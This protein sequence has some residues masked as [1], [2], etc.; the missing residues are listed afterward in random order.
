MTP[1]A[2]I[3]TMLLGQQSWSEEL[4]LDPPTGP[5][6]SIIHEDNEASQNAASRGASPDVS[7][8]LPD[9]PRTA[10]PAA[11]LS[12]S[13]RSTVI[14]RPGLGEEVRRASAAEE[15]ETDEAVRR[16]TLS[17]AVLTAAL[18]RR[19]QA[20]VSGV[21][22]SL[23]HVLK[24]AQGRTE[25][26][27][28]VLA[29][30]DLVLKVAQHHYAIDEVGELASIAKSLSADTLLLEAAVAT[31][32]ARRREAR[33]NAVQAQHELA[34]KAGW[35]YH[36]ESDGLPVPTETPILGRYDTKFDLIFARR[37]PPQLAC[38]IHGTLDLTREVIAADAASIISTL[39]VYH[40]LKHRFDRDQAAIE[41]VLRSHDQLHRSRVKFLSSV[42][43][44]N[45]D[46]AEYALVAASRTVSREQVVAML[47]PRRKGITDGVN[48]GNAQAAALNRPI[49][50]SPIVSGLRRAPRRELIEL[51]PVPKQK[52]R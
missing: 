34:E 40:E 50:R 16:F 37:P 41:D 23:S 12:G 8:A 20:S 51:Q 10:L 17:T 32:E 18:R 48:S 52:N 44:Y 6:A 28:I 36:G 3:T 27:R 35:P 31:A 7:W 33:L 15:I 22:T 9:T 45:H 38:R 19:D 5:P 1:F 25:R 24:E 39:R 26:R 30:W 49:L 46:I 21:E 13:A 42:L 29:Y 4:K 43:R 11:P 14:A 47:L 2:I